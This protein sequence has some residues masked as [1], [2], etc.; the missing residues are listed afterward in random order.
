M[1]KLRK[2]VTAFLNYGDKILLMKRS[3]NK[4]IAPNLWYGV[5]GHME[6]QEINDPYTSIY[7]EIFEETRINKDKIADLN[8]KY[9]VYNRE[10]EKQEIVVNYIF[11][12]K[13]NS[14]DL[15]SNNE[16]TLHWVYRDKVLEKDYH[17]AIRL[18]LEK[19]LSNWQEDLLLGVVNKENSSIQ[20]ETMK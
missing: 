6:P 10:T 7:R 18:I 1:L 17:P 15:V 16:G 2:I 11:H 9:I 12:G 13:V 14:H 3:P 5:G 8:L 19:Y 4:K 20:W